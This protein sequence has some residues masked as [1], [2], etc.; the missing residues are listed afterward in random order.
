MLE[1]SVLSSGSKANALYVTDGQT[2]L[3]IDCGL[4]AREISHRLARIGV[5]PQS[6]DAL[7][8]S[9]EHSDHI[10]GAPLFAKKH[11]LDVWATSGTFSV[12]N[13]RPDVPCFTRREF[14]AGDAFGIGALH[15]ETF[16]VLHDANDP[17][18]FRV[19]SGTT[20]LA[21]V[22]DL[23]AVT[24]A[25]SAHALNVDALVLESNHDLLL[26][27]E[28]H[29]PEHLKRRIR[30]NTGHLSN[31]QAADIVRRLSAQR[32]GRLQV[33]IGGHISENSNHPQLVRDSFHTAWGEGEANHLPE[34]LVAD[35]YSPTKIFSLAE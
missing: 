26:L 7:L 21:V 8:L 31:E 25:V 24:D 28:N 6:I 3:L 17:V 1:F 30:S 11:C 9:H 33:L 27:K 16:S 5:E 19:S 32:D 2:R 18:G 13:D 4:S 15:V 12:W 20:A 23:G 29:Y 34:I 22:T 10:R 35:I 14:R